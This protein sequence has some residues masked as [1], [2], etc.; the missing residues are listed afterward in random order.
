M[1]EKLIFTAAVTIIGCVAGDLYLNSKARI[2][3]VARRTF[4]NS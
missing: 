2:K 3:W 4:K 1:K